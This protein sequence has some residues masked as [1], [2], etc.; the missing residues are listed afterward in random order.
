M[1]ASGVSGS[2]I[3]EVAVFDTLAMENSIARS[4]TLAYLT[5]VA[6]HTLEIGN[7]EERIAALEEFTQ[8]K[9]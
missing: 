6:L 2:R 4:R 3:L 9:K 5:Q 7:L 1:E 8:E